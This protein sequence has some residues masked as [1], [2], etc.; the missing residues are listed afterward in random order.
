MK[1][2]MLDMDGTIC[3]FHDPVN[4]KIHMLDFPMGFFRNKRPLQSVLK[5]I[6]KDYRDYITIIFSASPNE[7][8]DKEKIEWLQQYAVA[9]WQHIF[10]RYPNSD[11]GQALM[12][13]MQRNNIKPEDI[14]II[15]DDHRVLR[16]C[17]KLGV[18][19]VHPSHLVAEYESCPER[20]N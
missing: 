4:N 1:Y 11:K 20:Y 16:S 6:L 14:T 13:F 8:A 3:E 2:L 5:V 18:H 12:I 19:C 7:Q 10:L 9:N 15:D 17:E